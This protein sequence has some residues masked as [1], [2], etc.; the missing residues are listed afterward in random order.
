MAN[1]NKCIERQLLGADEL[2]FCYCHSNRL[3]IWW[4]LHSELPMACLGVSWGRQTNVCPFAT[5][6]VE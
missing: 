3:Q 2:S 5:C 4:G 6:T 1:W